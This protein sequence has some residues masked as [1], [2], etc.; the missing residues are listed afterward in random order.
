MELRLKV[1]G[2]L[3]LVTMILR[4]ERRRLLLG[5]RKRIRPWIRLARKVAL[6]MI[7]GTIRL[8]LGWW[9]LATREV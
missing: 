9:V 6:E 3:H 8:R 4:Y 5:C 7:T 1:R 2:R